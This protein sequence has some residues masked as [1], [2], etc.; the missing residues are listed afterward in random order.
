[1]NAPLYPTNL[2][3]PSD[4]I[5]KK[6]ELRTYQHPLVFA[7]KNISLIVICILAQSVSRGTPLLNLKLGKDEII[8]STPRTTTLTLR[9]SAGFRHN[10]DWTVLQFVETIK[11]LLGPCTNSF[12]VKYFTFTINIPVPSSTVHVFFISTFLAV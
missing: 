4:D 5:G 9:D 3:I 10:C 6:V 1:M 12:N 2:S 7:C 11:S 8:W